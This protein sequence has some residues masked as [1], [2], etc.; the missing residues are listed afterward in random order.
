MKLSNRGQ[1]ERGGGVEVRFLQLQLAL[2]FV[3][4]SDLVSG[5]Q[6]H[7]TRVISLK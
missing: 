6:L 1:L 4:I 5:L 3:V 7:L 2:V